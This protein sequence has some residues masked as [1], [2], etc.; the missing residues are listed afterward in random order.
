MWKN[1]EPRGKVFIAVLAIALLG[2]A[3]YWF[4]GYS[5]KH[6]TLKKANQDLVNTK[7]EV[8]PEADAVVAYNTFIGV[9]GLVLENNGM[10]PT[11]DCEFFKKYG[12]KIQIKQIDKS[13]DVRDGLTVGALDLAYCTTDALSIA[14][15][16]GSTFLSQGIREIMKVNESRG[17]DAIVAVGGITKVIDLKGKKIAFAVGTASHTLLLNVLE[18]A[19]L[20]MKDITAYEV[21]DGVE[22][23]AAFKAGQCDAALVWAPDDGDCVTAVKGSSILISTSTATQIIAD[24]LLVSE[25]VLKEKH[26]IIYKI[27]K[28]WLEG[29]ARINTSATSKKEAIALFSKGFGFP[30][31]LSTIAVDKVRFCTVADNKQFFGFD[32][33]YTGVTGEK[34][35]SRMA[36]KY[37][38]AGLANAPAPWRNVSDGSIIE[39]LIADASIANAPNQ[40]VPEPVKF[41]APVAADYTAPAKGSKAVTISFAV[42]SA[43]LDEFAKS[44]IEQSITGTAEGFQNARVRIEG[45]TDNTGNKAI[46][47]PLSKRRAQA[48]ASYLISEHKF[49]KNKFIVVGNGSDVPVP[50]CEANADEECRARNRRTEFQVIW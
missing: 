40:G 50:G 11:E 31:D 23:A 37:T 44:T 30:E 43:D 41:A 5:Q 4:H 29:N 9:A 25:K 17:A 19:G 24:G 45:N 18:T 14:M 22:A 38:E 1:L 3:A 35:Y 42:N 7:F 36:V 39:E 8:N 34:M 47:K 33:T 49:D 2:G 32:P 46:N 26:D 16:S 20:T 27:C 21:G 28:G 6:G 10:E 15:S 12:I 48:V 13:A